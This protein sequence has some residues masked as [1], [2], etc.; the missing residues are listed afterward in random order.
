MATEA[1]ACGRAQSAF[2]AAMASPMWGRGL[3]TLPV[4]KDPCPRGAWMNFW[5]NCAR[6]WSCPLSLEFCSQDMASRLSNTMRT[7]A[8][9]CLV[10]SPI[11]GTKTG[12]GA[13]ASA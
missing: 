10:E 7:R 1:A 9:Y 6:F 2:P 8:L 12:T 5:Q 3:A 4:M 11:S 13:C